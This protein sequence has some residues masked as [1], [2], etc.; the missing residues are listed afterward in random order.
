MDKIPYVVCTRINL[1]LDD[2]REGLS[3]C[4]YTGDPSQ[5]C[6]QLDLEQGFFF[7]EMAAKISAHMTCSN[8][9][10]ILVQ[11]FRINIRLPE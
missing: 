11:I 6:L 9:V 8:C 10:V 5:P 7:N 3:F 4:S 1:W 2:A